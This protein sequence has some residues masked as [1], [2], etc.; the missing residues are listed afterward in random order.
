MWSRVRVNSLARLS[1]SEQQVMISL[2]SV[3]HSGE[4]F[5]CIAVVREVMVSVQVFQSEEVRNRRPSSSWA[6]MPR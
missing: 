5:F 4:G 6:W 1:I 2:H 3:M